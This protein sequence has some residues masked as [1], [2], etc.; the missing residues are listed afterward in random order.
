MRN[1][2]G[3]YLNLSEHALTRA[4][5][6]ASQAAAVG[7]QV[8]PP[9]LEPSSNLPGLAADLSGN[10]ADLGSMGDADPVSLRRTNSQA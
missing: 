10:S 2:S 1:P 6:L 9:A 8:T 7:G 5:Q 3:S 4:E